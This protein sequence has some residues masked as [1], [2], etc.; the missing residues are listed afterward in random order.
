MMTNDDLCNLESWG[1]PPQ[2]LN[3]Y[4][5]RGILSMF[6]W[7]VECLTSE[8]VLD[9][10]N[11]VY[12]APT[13]AGK[14]MVAEI[15]AMQTVL[16]RDKKVLI[17]LPFVSVVREKMLYFQELFE[18]TNK[19]VAGFMGSYTPP[20]GLRSVN[21][22]IA[23]IEKA[24][25]LI[26][27]L[28]E[29]DGLQ[30]IGC[31]IVDELHMLGDS[32]RGYLLELLLTKIKYMSKIRSN[33]SVQIIGMS[34]TLPNLEMLAKWLDA[35]LYQTTFRPIP[36]KEYLK[37][38]KNIYNAKDC[39]LSHT[40]EPDY[41]IKN[42]PDN[43]THLS[44]DTILQGYSILIFC[45]TKKWCESL[46]IEI[47]SEIKRL[48]GDTKSKTG[49]ALRNQL[50]GESLGDVLEQLRRCPVG[51]EPELNKT[52]SFG[53][54]FHHAGL[55]MDERD[56]IE[57]AFKQNVVRV[58]VATS[59]LSS[60]VNLPARRVIVRSPACHGFPIDILQYR[61]MI[62]RAGRMGV[63][64]AGE[65]YLIC[66]EN[67]KRIGEQLA[68]QDL[69]PIKSCLGV[70]DFSNCLKRALLEVVASCVVNSKEEA[71]KYM[72]CTLLYAS[73]GN[74]F[75]ENPIH[76]CLKLL[77]EHQFVQESQ[78]KLA[79]TCL[80][81]ACLAASV[82]PDIGLK[83]IK[84]LDRARQNFVLDSELHLL[85][86]IT[87]YSVSDQIGNLD[88]FRVLNIWEKLP[89]ALRKVGEMVGVEERF[90]VKAMTGTT[91][92]SLSD[93]HKLAIHRR[94]YT[95]LLLHDLINEVPINTIVSKYCTSKGLLQSLQ[96]SS[97]TFAGMVTQFCKR[98]G[99]SSLELLISQF[100]E[101]LQFGVQRQLVDL[102]RLDCLNSITARAIY[103]AEI[104]NV[105]E[106][107]LA[108]IRHVQRALAKAIPYQN[109]TNNNMD[110]EEKRKNIWL[111]GRFALNEKD[112]ATFII[113]EARHLLKRE[114]GLKSACWIEDCNANKTLD[115]S[116]NSIKIRPSTSKNVI[117]IENSQESEKFNDQN[118]FHSPPSLSKSSVELFPETNSIVNIQ[119]EEIKSKD[120]KRESLDLFDGSFEH[121]KFSLTVHASQKDNQINCEKSIGNYYHTELVYIKTPKEHEEIW[122]CNIGGESILELSQKDIGSRK[123]KREEHDIV[124]N[125][126]DKNLIEQPSKYKKVE[127][128]SPKSC[129][130]FE[131]T[132]F[133]DS[134]IIDTQLDMLINYDDKK[135]N[136]IPVVSNSID[137][138]ANSL[139]N[140]S[141]NM[142]IKNEEMSESLLNAAFQSSFNI[143][144]NVVTNTDKTKQINVNKEEA[145]SESIMKEAFQNSFSSMANTIICP[146]KT[147]IINGTCNDLVI[148][149]SE[150]MIAGSQDTV[151]SGPSPRKESPMKPDANANSIKLETWA[152]KTK[153][154]EN[155]DAFASEY[156]PE[157][158]YRK[159]ITLALNICK[160]V[161]IENKIG[162]KFLR[163]NVEHC[164]HNSFKYDNQVLKGF[165]LTWYKQTV[166]HYAD[167][168]KIGP[169]G[170]SLLRKLLT[171]KNLTVNVYDAKSS[172]KMISQC[173][174]IISVC[175][176]RDP[177]VADWLISGQ[178]KNSLESLIKWHL[179]FNGCIP[180][181]DSVFNAFIVQKLMSSLKRQLKQIFIYKTFKDIEMPIQ[182]IL[183]KMELHG[184][185]VNKE[186]VTKLHNTVNTLMD[187]ISKEAC[188]LSG[189][190]F[191]MQS[192]IEWAKVKRNLNLTD[193][194]S[195]PLVELIKNWR[196]LSSLRNNH[197]NFLLTTTK[198]TVYC[199][200]NTYSSTGRISM[201]EPNLQNLPKDYIIENEIISI[202]SSFI[203]KSDR[204]LVS[205][206]FCQIELRV[207][208]HLSKDSKLI[209]SLKSSGDVFV[210]MSS[211]WHKIPESE[212]CDELRQKTKQVC[213]GILYGMGAITLSETLDISEDEAHKLISEFKSTFSDINKFFT[214]CIIQCRTLGLVKTLSGRI[215][216]LPDIKSENPKLRAQAERQA[217]NTIIQ[218]SAAD[219]T[220]IAMIKVDKTINQLYAKPQIHLL[221]H[222]HDEL[223]FE[224]HNSVLDEACSLITSTM[225]SAVNLCVPLPVKIKKGSNWG[226]LK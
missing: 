120:Y 223:I 32:N 107:A 186:E 45:F 29:E 92:N 12:S 134:L 154:I 126:V 193:T 221:M 106:L 13:S 132:M 213:Y 15:L 82:T 116:L 214:D 160:E 7:Q 212:V 84:E 192:K 124:S 141:K 204:T 37:V 140:K 173:C 33:I 50:N 76:Q 216:Y 150:D 67:E 122:D 135:N 119:H 201:H 60:G 66:N 158:K 68:C 147:K 166:V 14:T 179:N 157:I 25:G 219:V 180:S 87:P 62:G 5:K 195:H 65:S 35:T 77:I 53:V 70:G 2:I 168:N 115:E 3:N 72:Q 207:L 20:G 75:N 133:P 200:S 86:L 52:I 145:L 61:Q 90:I 91:F 85:Y 111:A 28:M 187:N 27:R 142:F 31:V 108:D 101:R 149:D 55:T 44:I 139:N 59:T 16:E 22:A 74:N 130:M 197:L 17:V 89:Q 47:A 57:G 69:P 143:T 80:G 98:L 148:S 183:A 51:L 46:A 217:I 144:T 30:D 39:S 125:E 188:S 81:Q 117:V 189:I 41:G 71:L 103:N 175:K 184:F 209:S 190:Q 205:V 23:T 24:N 10:R 43:V 94:F 202:R 161:N 174:G 165:A 208:A 225:A 42:D 96:Q 164:I 163:L 220:K 136:N 152:Y 97:S 105:P 159:E 151:S 49:M 48:G 185:S 138:Q 182:I 78:N 56:I 155:I 34:A 11:L 178:P 58:L 63:D 206:D 156:F 102:L 218:G 100:E 118:S 162:S 110:D 26:N 19:R 146:D 191:N 18:G 177:S 21:V 129:N 95:S 88:W 38:G 222:L 113:N 127:E 196:K 226:E 9:G 211:K 171:N 83:L 167:L 36:L 210:H 170:I 1:L 109:N 99:W 112:A 199:D 73:T 40:I 64:T 224:V 203:P 153:V 198:D 128:I 79:P 93:K 123:R 169:S 215:R 4:K 194:S 114:L 104:H 121:T 54:A 172:Y 137:T 181:N 131:S 8:S 176:F 6:P